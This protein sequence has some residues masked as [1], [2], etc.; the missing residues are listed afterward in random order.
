MVDDV[1]WLISCVFMDN[2][3]WGL[4]LVGLPLAGAREENKIKNAC[5]KTFESVVTTHCSRKRPVDDQA[6]YSYHFPSL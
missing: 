5:G 4:C 6:L 1:L 3:S 2:L